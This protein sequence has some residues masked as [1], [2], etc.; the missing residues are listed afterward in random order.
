MAQQT[1][2]EVGA[3]TNDAA[4]QINDNFT[5]VYNFTPSADAVLGPASA[6]D[7]DVVVYDGT[8]GK[9]VQDTSLVAAD[10]VTG[11]ASVTANKVVLF[12]GTTGKLIKADSAGVSAGP[13]TSIT[14]ITVVDGLVTDL[15]GS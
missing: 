10:V 5:E 14:S 8:T 6:V 13:F 2:T 11:P 4:K 3:F 15:Q 1:I 9:L 7:G 12:N